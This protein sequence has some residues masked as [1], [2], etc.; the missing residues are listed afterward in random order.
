MRRKNTTSK[1][2]KQ[3]MAE[4]LLILMK[5]KDFHEISIGALTKKAGVHRSTYYR[6]F[7]SKEE[8]LRFYFQ[9]IIE[10]QREKIPSNQ[11]EFKEYMLQMFTHYYQYKEH[12]LLI[13]RANLS[14]L[15]LDVFNHVFQSAHGGDTPKDSYF[16]YYH[17]GGIYNNFILW[18]SNN[19]QE[20]PEEITAIIC[21]F[22]PQNFQPM[23]TTLKSKKF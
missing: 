7:Q 18:F 15:M 19:M 13:Y 10:L 8:I 12:L 23:L 4:A 20:T 6:N 9:Q 21:S 3:Y 14:Y 2:M 22:F 16:T 11:L 1:T 5:D 17:T